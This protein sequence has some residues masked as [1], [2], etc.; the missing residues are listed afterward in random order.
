VI[1]VA[2]LFPGIWPLV[3]T[4]VCGLKIEADIA[5]LM[6]LTFAVAAGGIALIVFAIRNR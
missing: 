5:G 4:G 2:L 6:L 1:G 3:F